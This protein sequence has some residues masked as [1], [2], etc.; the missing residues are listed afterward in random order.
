MAERKTVMY[1]VVC[2]GHTI[3]DD[4]LDKVQVHNGRLT[5]E[6]GKT[7]LFDFTIWSD[8]PH[9]D[10]VQIIKPIVEVFRDDESIFRGR[11]LDIKIGM[12]G[13]KQVSCEGELAFLYDSFFEPQMYYGGFVDFLDNVISQHNY[14]VEAAKQFKAGAVTVGDLFPFEV[15]QT[16]WKTTLDT[17]VERMVTPSSGYL[18][19]R[20]EGGVRY[21]DLLSYYVDISNQS[22][23]DIILGKNLL[24]IKQ[25]INGG[26]VF[27][28]I[29]P[30]GAEV[31]GNRVDIRS[32]NNGS[33]SILNQEAV[34]LY[35]RIYKV[36]T[37]DDIT[38]AATLKLRAANYLAEQFAAATTVEITAADLSPIG[39]A[40]DTFRVGQWVNV[41]SEYHFD[42]PQLFLI[43]N[44]SIMLS[45]PSE[46]RITIGRA[47]QGLTDS[48]I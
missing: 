30:L 43:R 16:E 36:V 10:S 45:D 31:G 29:I 13:E 24:D 38:D 28:G 19:V 2:D 1:R 39:L 4:R 3:H 41:I 25:E 18:Q 48:I 11:V 8:N 20:H 21:V 7:G 5:L 44:S 33:P 37:F 47:K 22:A 40:A 9:F 17:L 23:Q 32:V 46:T 42:Q 34:A 6:L 26:A 15:D 14:Q 27:S 35:G 12:Y